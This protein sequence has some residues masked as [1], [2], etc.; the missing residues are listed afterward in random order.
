[1]YNYRNKLS[2]ICYKLRFF[3]FK[4]SFENMLKLSLLI[5]L[6]GFYLKRIY[7]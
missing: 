3:I 2:N 5:V 7:M 1:M 4:L 6:Y